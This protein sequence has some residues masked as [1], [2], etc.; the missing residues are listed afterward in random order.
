MLRKLGLLSVFCF[1]ISVSF[2]QNYSSN[3]KKAIKFFEEGMELG[4]QRKDEMAIK[5]LQDALRLDPNF[6]EAYLIIGQIYQDK[7]Q[8]KEAVDAYQAAAKIDEKKFSDAFLYLGDIFMKTSVF[9]YA[10]KSYEKFLKYAKFRN[11]TDRFIYEKLIE[12]A[13]F[14]DSLVKHPV[15]FVPRNL[16]PN[17]N[18]VHDEYHPT[19]PADES[20]VIYTVRAPSATS[21]CVKDREEDFYI[22]YKTEKGW[23]PRENMG[24]PINSACNEGAGNISPDG[25]FLFFAAQT[26]NREDVIGRMPSMDL[27]YA[28]KIGNSWSIPE[29]LGEPVNTEG[30]E[31][32]PSFSSDGKTLYFTSNRPGGFGG[33]DIWKTIR[34][35]DGSWSEPENLGPEINTKG[36]EVSPYIHPDNQTLYFVSDGRLGV[37]GFDIYY[38]KKDEKGQF[39]DAT[40]I[41]YPI[42]T[43]ADER[44][45]MITANGMSAYYASKNSDGLGLYDLYMFDVPLSLQG[46]Y[47]TYLKGNIYDKESKQKIQASFELIDLEKGETII[48]S[49]SDKSD[50]SFVLPIPVKTTTYAINVYKDGYLF[51]SDNIEINDTQ[52]EKTYQKDIPLQA[53]KIGTSVVMKN[54]FFDTDK[55]DLKKESLAELKKLVALL[56]SNPKLVIEIGGHTDNQGSK[57]HNQTL[58]QNRAQAVLN[59]LVSQ[60]IAKERLTS[61]GYGDAKPIADNATEEGRQQ[62][63]RT[64]FTVL[65]M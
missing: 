42:N 40:N 28:E 43:P 20:F 54:I 9:D 10:A 5:K 29:N 60:G 27:Y 22:S 59:Y 49:V 34:Q 19:L 62:N 2:A 53:I 16:G 41:G 57:A 24:G 47:V 46:S 38:A 32:Q 6:G 65:K 39:V 36:D 4:R 31:S 33:T 30:F 51:Y 50:G 63:R 14:A 8:L 45:F 61:K 52:K 37:G 15:E 3:N 58:S 12:K 7:N 11:P 25:R 48:K 35:E 56:K 26:R 13:Q 64:E 18:S 44:S 17:V 55:F 23:S 1:F 21:A